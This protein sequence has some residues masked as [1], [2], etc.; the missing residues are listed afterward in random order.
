M[1]RCRG[2]EEVKREGAVDS[3]LTQDVSLYR[4]VDVC[5]W[6][7]GRNGT[8]PERQTTQYLPGGLEV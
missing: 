1:G 2:M 7:A 4:I 5:Q 3:R 8:A 6:L